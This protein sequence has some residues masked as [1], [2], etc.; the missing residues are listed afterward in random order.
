MS[1]TDYT[2]LNRLIIVFLQ[3]LSMGRKNELFCPKLTKSDEE[4]LPRDK[5]MEFIDHGNFIL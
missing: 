5:N 2:R 1:K 3:T 4:R